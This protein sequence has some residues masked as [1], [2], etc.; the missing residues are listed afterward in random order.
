ML[1]EDSGTLLV[2]KCSGLRA[3]CAR[4]EPDMLASALAQQGPFKAEMLETE[5]ESDV[6]VEDQQS[7]E[8]CCVQTRALLLLT[9]A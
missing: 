1:G 4:P 2:S 9:G 3:E 7:S 8:A 5:A 6:F